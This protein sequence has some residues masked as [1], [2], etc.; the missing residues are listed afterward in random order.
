MGLYCFWSNKHFM[1][2]ESY[3]TNRHQSHLSTPGHQAYTQKLVKPILA[4]EP[5][6]WQPFVIYALSVVA[7]KKPNPL[8]KAGI[9]QTHGVVHLRC[10]AAREDSQSCRKPLVAESKYLWI[11]CKWLP[12]RVHLLVDR[13]TQ[14]KKQP[15]QACLQ[16]WIQESEANS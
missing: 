13:M 5:K 7:V 14:A 1:D 9:S 8:L 3:S 6:N 4:L 12:W 15:V 2:K 16:D 10:P 11:V